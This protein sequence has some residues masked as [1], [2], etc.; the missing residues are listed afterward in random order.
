MRSAG[1]GLLGRS[2]A[3]SSG[4]TARRSTGG[5]ARP[6]GK[7]GPRSAGL[8]GFFKGVR[9]GAQAASQKPAPAP[10]TRKPEPA[11]PEPKPATK[12]TPRNDAERK[13]IPQPRVTPKENRPMIQH[14]DDSS[15]Q[16]WGR[17]LTTVGPA[18]EEFAKTTDGH[19]E[20]AGQLAT[21]VGRLASQGDDELPAAKSVT[22][23]A[24]AIAA[25]LKQVEAEAAAA[26]GKLRSLAGRA[27]ALGASYRR[28]H[29][30]DE[31]RLA[32]E[33]GGRHKEK[34]ADVGQA[35]QDT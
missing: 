30:T 10:S 2:G 19:A 14:Q 18:L 32:G 15:L 21:A 17:N 31:A 23:E 13:P 33:R 26:A 25:E 29:E 12:Q 1:R 5:A 22:A 16:K 11:K 8:A 4:A 34:R 20:F 28:N 3:R 9:E 27:D 7:S 6:A 35:E 24:A